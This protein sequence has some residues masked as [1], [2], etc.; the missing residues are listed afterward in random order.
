MTQPVDVMK[1]RMMNAKPGEFKGIMDCFF[2]T[3]KTGPSTF[4]KGL[5]PAF[6]RL[7]KL[8]TF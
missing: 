8:L 4:F 2:F 5:V 7:G 3:L 1:T 6:I